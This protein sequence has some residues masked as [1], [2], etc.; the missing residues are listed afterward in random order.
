[1]HGVHKH[2]RIAHV[3]I[4]CEA[5]LSQATHSQVITLQ[6]ND[7]EDVPLE[8]GC[9]ADLKS[10]ETKDNNRLKVPVDYVRQQVRIVTHRDPS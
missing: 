2:S 6:N 1:M 10:V 9:C 5:T 3:F 8:L 4:I 7:L